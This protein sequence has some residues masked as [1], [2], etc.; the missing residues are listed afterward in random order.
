[1]NLRKRPADANDDTPNHRPT[2][3]TVG[4]QAKTLAVLWNNILE[5]VIT[6]KHNIS[7]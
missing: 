2:C 3:D 4:S 6:S 5:Y 7:V 1:M